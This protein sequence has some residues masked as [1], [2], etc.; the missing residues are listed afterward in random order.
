MIDSYS[1]LGEGIFFDEVK[2]SLFWVDIRQSLLFSYSHGKVYKYQL[3]ENVSTV[4]FVE[5]NLVYLTNRSGIISFDLASGEIKQISKTPTQFNPKEYRAN[6]GTRLSKGMYLYGVMRDSPVKNDGALILS[7][8]KNSRVVY[9]GIAIP[10]TFIRIPNTNTLLITDSFD[11]IVYKVDFDN[12][13]ESVIKKEKWIDFSFENFTP[14]GGCISSD[15]RVFI[16]IWDGFKVL[17]LD[18]HGKLIKEFNVPIPRPTNCA[19][20]ASESQLFVTSA[21]EGL[22]D[23]ERNKYMLSGSIITINLN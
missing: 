16:A 17:Q 2:N 19:L 15:G 3:V 12:L 8:N 10:N 23:Y 7:R 13:W 6:D 22:S 11:G 5:N 1:K 20:S 14:D 9:E 18:L 4:L 21:Y